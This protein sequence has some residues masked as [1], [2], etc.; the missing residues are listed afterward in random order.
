[1][2]KVTSWGSSDAIVNGDAGVELIPS[3]NPLTVTVTVLLNP[4]CLL[5]DTTAGGLALPT[6][7]RRVVGPTVKLKFGLGVRD[8]ELGDPP[9]PQLQ[10]QRSRTQAASPSPRGG[11]P[12]MIPFSTLL[13]TGRR[14]YSKAPEE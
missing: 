6:V 12:V 4:F 1:M 7:A 13:Q 3:A 11:L 5:M 9:P 10:L 14:K 8:G 2:E